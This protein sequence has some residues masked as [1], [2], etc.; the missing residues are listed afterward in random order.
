MKISVVTPTIRPQ[1]LN[2]T[3]ECLKK[4]TFKNFEWLVDIDFP[5]DRFLLPKAMNR[6]L[7]R[8]QGEIIV[9]LQDCI[10]IPENFLEHV[11][12]SYN[13]DFVT[14][15]VGNAVGVGGFVAK[16]FD[17]N[18]ILRRVLNLRSYRRR[19]SDCHPAKVG[20]LRA[21]AA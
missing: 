5:S 12:N 7:K 1:Y 16:N 18:I 15:P 21:Y 3:Y 13:G 9:H 10:K 8:S 2:L 20:P 4:Q 14:Y 17:H 6:L 19:N 11:Y